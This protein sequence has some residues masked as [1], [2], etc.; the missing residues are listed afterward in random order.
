VDDEKPQNTNSALWNGMIAPL[1]RLAIFGFLWYQGEANTG[2]N[3][4]KYACTFEAMIKDWRTVFR[5]QDAP[6][7]FVQLSTIKFGNTGLYY[8]QLRW[9]QTA[10]FGTVP[11][12]KLERVYMAMAVD[13][14]DEPN[15]IHP[16]YKQI[17]ADRLAITGL[18]TAYGK[19]FYPE[20]GPTVVST[21]AT[22]EALLL[23]YSQA[24][25][26]N[27]AELSGFYYCCEE[28][29]ACFTASSASSWPEVNKEEVSLVDDKTIS[30]AWSG[31]PLCPDSSVPSLAYLWR[32]TPIQTPTG[33][34]PIY[35]ADEYGLPAEPWIWYSA[36]L[37]QPM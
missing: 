20:H 2:W 25:T 23:T 22:E 34:A 30:L 17:V 37:P 13:T 8:P 29:A 6:F 11:N 15:G 18:R 28:D 5:V 36:D 33:G 21:A 16:W 32:E 1:G 27:T 26:L 10:D 35:A 24:I 14:Y 19:T 9:H 31:L 4:D 12:A 7:G 3:R